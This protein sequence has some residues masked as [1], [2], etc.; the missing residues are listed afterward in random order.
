M[1]LSLAEVRRLRLDPTDVMSLLADQVRGAGTG[2]QFVGGTVGFLVRGD[3]GGCWI[4]DL[5]K[6]GGEWTEGASEPA[7]ARCSTRI[8]SFARELGAI[9]LAPDAITGLL[10]T[11]FIVVEG[12]TE[13]LH[14]L[15]KLIEGRGGASAVAIRT[16]RG[17]RT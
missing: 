13:K 14:R 1:S 7:F 4:L 3:P 16:N 12:D 5:S 2:T 10:E 6:P 11:G 8:F 9:L 17:E 15:G